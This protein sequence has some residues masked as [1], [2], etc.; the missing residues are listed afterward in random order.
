MRVTHLLALG[1]VLVALSGA[2]ALGDH[3]SYP[4]TLKLGVG[5][6]DLEAQIN[7][8]PWIMNTSRAEYERD[9]SK[10]NFGGRD[11]RCATVHFELKGLYGANFEGCK[12]DGSSLLE[13]DFR[14]C[15]FRSTSLRFCQ[16]DWSSWAAMNDFT[17]ADI[18]GSYIIGASGEMLQQ[19]RN[20]REGRLFGIRIL[21]GDMR[22]LSF[23]GM[24]LEAC[25]LGD[26]RGCDFTDAT[27]RRMVIYSCYF[28][29]H[30]L[31]TTKNGQRRDY[32][33]LLF[34]GSSNPAKGQLKDDFRGWDFSRCNL[35]YFSG[36]N[37]TEA[38]FHDAYFLYPA[39]TVGGVFRFD[40]GCSDW[41]PLLYYE[42]VTSGF[43]GFDGCLLAEA[44]LHQTANWKRKD[45][46]GMHLRNMKLE[47]WDFSGMNMED[48]DL[49][50]SSL[51]GAKFTDA[52]I[53]G[54]KLVAATG[55]T[56][57]QLQESKTFRGRATAAILGAHPHAK[58]VDLADEQRV[59]EQLRRKE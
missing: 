22:G 44:Q 1:C 52:N 26:V 21:R 27:L 15:S 12:L 36:C 3:P 7:S 5:N 32:S 55:L 42:T 50:G 10:I 20:Y 35:A 14:A 40:P 29:E 2:P 18:E 51:K 16:L 34:A 53:V 24:T 49:S 23:R 4:Y 43:I 31:R 17:N 30:Q 46:R 8:L 9:A 45:L 56:I 11:L 33:E 57:A 28:S 25:N 54:L 58:F 19:T 38:R 6:E 13:T 37:L 59:L 48:A 47:G 39:D 41:S